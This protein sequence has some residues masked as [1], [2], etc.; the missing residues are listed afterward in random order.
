MILNLF[1]F[2]KL[3]A[4]GRLAGSEVEMKSLREELGQQ[5]EATEEA[6]KM[7]K[8]LAAK[9]REVAATSFVSF[10]SSSSFLQL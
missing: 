10:S 1:C 4:S 7:V 3:S 9:E 8:G 2:S 5:K 6:Q